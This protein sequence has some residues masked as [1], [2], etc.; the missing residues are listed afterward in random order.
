MRKY[1]IPFQ[2]IVRVLES[3]DHWGEIAG[4]DDL[5]TYA[6]SWAELRKGL[7]LRCKNLLEDYEPFELAGLTHEKKIDTKEIELSLAPENKTHIWKGELNLKFYYC[8]WRLPNGAWTARIPDLQ[9]QVVS[10]NLEGLIP[11]L[12]K[13]ASLSL[14]YLIENHSLK[15]I[16]F[17]VRTSRIYIEKLT[18]EY[19][20][21]TPLD[22]EKGENE[23]SSDEKS[24]LA[25]VCDQLHSN[26]VSPSWFADK[27]V[28]QLG[29]NFSN[30]NPEPIL[31][32][33]ESGVGKS[34]IYNQ[35]FLERKNYGLENWRFFTTAGAR[36]VAGQTGYGMWQ[37]QCIKLVREISGNPVI[38]HLGN[39]VEL[40]QSG[41]FVGNRQGIGSFLKDPIQKGELLCCVEATPEQIHVV[42]QEDPQLLN[43]FKR[44]HVSQ[45]TN[46]VLTNILESYCRHFYPNLIA[47]T[48]ALEKLADLHNQYA[49]YSV[50]P[51][52]PL[53]FLRNLL[54][55]LAIDQVLRSSSSKKKAKKNS[56]S[57]YPT[58]VAIQLTHNHVVSEFAKQTG[59][60]LFMLKPEEKLNI[61]EAS[62]WFNKA[63]MGQESAVSKVV[64]LLA[65]TKA[66]MSKRNKPIGSL[67]FIGPTGVGKTELAK[68]LAKYLFGNEERIIRFDMGEYSDPNAHLRLIFSRGS[69]EG[70]LTAKV[71][72]Q[73]FSVVLLDE[74]EKASPRVF[75]LL[76]Q[77]L[78]EGRLTD[79][80]GRVADF[81]NTV[82]IMT[83]NL[84]VKKYQTGSLGFGDSKLQDP[85]DHFTSEVKK[86]LRPEMFNRI[87]A[88]VPF[89]PL[90]LRSVQKITEFQLNSVMH[91]DGIRGRG[92]ELHYTDEVVS[93]IAKLGFDPRYGARPLKRAIE[94]YILKPLAKQLAGGNAEC[95]LKV[96]LSIAENKKQK[97]EK[98][99]FDCHTK[100]DS[101][102]KPIP[103]SLSED[104]A[105][106]LA[107]SASSHRRFIY[108]LPFK[109]IVISTRSRMSQ[110]EVLLQSK[111]SDSSY[112]ES[113][114]QQKQKAE[115]DFIK[116][117][118]NALESNTKS[119]NQFE[120]RILTAIYAQRDL[121][122]DVENKQIKDIF[123]KTEAI[124]H[125]FYKSKKDV[126]SK[127]IVCLIHGP[128]KSLV[129]ALSKAYCEISFSHKF[130][131]RC[132]HIHCSK[133]NHK[134]TAIDLDS[135]LQ[136]K[137][138]R[139]SVYSG[140]IL[141]ISGVD[142][143]FK[144]HLEKGIHKFPKTN[145]DR[146]CLV[147]FQF[148]KFPEDMKLKSHIEESDEIF[149]PDYL[150]ET[151]IPNE[152]IEVRKFQEI[153]DGVVR[154]V[155]DS[156]V[157]KN[158]AHGDLVDVIVELCEQRLK[159][160]IE[161]E[162]E[163]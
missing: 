40:L 98:F 17:L 134:L 33:G 59:L 64:D 4:F 25:K 91:R 108:S 28:H 55:D 84:G 107:Q 35:F 88:I 38:I 50:A 39:I 97:S 115:L 76:L 3:G 146:W 42:E 37:E 90:D 85:T 82:I 157:G 68:T 133:E 152:K 71:R 95:A 128:S 99:H 29:N 87:D 23:T 89:G 111:K 160:Q 32:V 58:S 49:T 159:L 62:E 145:T 46:P 127:R 161:K 18:V 153:D 51:G 100:V 19:E 77:V 130:Q 92:V 9:L 11:K 110:L 142:V 144:F 148:G 101:D 150:G 10:Q 5:S 78:G 141:E 12:Q 96:N 80:A 13:Y 75:D 26:E 52:R 137:F 109:N 56:S 135:I 151:R 27:Y 114:D 73:P 60:P 54:E 41:R 156:I 74:F 113:N 1:Q 158:K 21:K 57:Q 139:T 123:N 147:D 16:L 154:K 124:K 93:H 129:A 72:E 117:T 70:L 149:L 22:I 112:K 48:G 104:S 94:S 7:Q 2:C 122:V 118:F 44:V 61:D 79:A 143:E 24:V 20:G 66:G 6:P 121:E 132:F 47:E 140:M 15:Y 136:K 102:G 131:V 65:V 34:T 155:S 105:L 8:E 63:V 103:I 45:P 106:A 120:D 53:K 30:L 86:F 14:R 67:L 125:A 162:F 83:S 119:I 69:D 116:S 138:D 43:L 36:L 126:L 31:L 163:S 81:S